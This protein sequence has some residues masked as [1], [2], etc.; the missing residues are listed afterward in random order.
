MPRHW[1]S[2]RRCQQLGLDLKRFE[3]DRV[4]RGVIALA[5]IQKT[6]TDDDLSLV[7]ERVRQELEDSAASSPTAVPAENGYGH[8][9]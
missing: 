4:Y 9:V 6:M 2:S 1:C 3:L 5:D 8:G 7:V